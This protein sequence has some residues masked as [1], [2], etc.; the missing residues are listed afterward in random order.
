MP[1]DFPSEVTTPLG[2]LRTITSGATSFASDVVA[3]LTAAFGTGNPFGTAATRNT[4]T[5]AG[6]VPLLASGGRIEPSLVPEA[7]ETARGGVIVARDIADARAGVVVTAAQVAAFAAAAGT[8]LN[9]ANL[10]VTQLQDGVDFTAP[11][12]GLIVVGA[13]GGGGHRPPADTNNYLNDGLGANAADSFLWYA[14]RQTQSSRLQVRGGLGGA[15]RGSQAS[16]QGIAF[17][18]VPAG[19][20][21]PDF[22][23]TLLGKGGPGGVA[24]AYINTTSNTLPSYAGVPGGDG[25]LLI[26]KVMAAT[27][28]VTLGA[29]G[30]GGAALT[31]LSSGARSTAGGTGFAAFAFY[32]RLV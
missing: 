14:D 3:L 20:N 10:A 1:A 32:M 24:G 12:V 6:Q 8:G 31:G 4:G 21:R 17:P 27:Y 11:A 28:R 15:Q 19:D 7:T 30:A 22:A 29:A 25:E 23:I 26:A 16:P 18:A 13:A 2:R 5:N 9:A